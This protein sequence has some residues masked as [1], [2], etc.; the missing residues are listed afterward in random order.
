MP[1]LNIQIVNLLK[2]NNFNETEIEVLEQDLVQKI[3]KP[4]NIEVN[5][6]E[7]DTLNRYL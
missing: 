5:L 4:L 2:S 6:F 7:F 3:N 1:Q